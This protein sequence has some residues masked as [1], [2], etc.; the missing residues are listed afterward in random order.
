MESDI[1]C[2]NLETGAA[3]VNR[4]AHHGER[5]F[6]KYAQQIVIAERRAIIDCTHELPASS[7]CEPLALLRVTTSYQLEPISEVVSRFPSEL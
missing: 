4:A 7:Q 1:G 2:R 3:G 6:G 5:C